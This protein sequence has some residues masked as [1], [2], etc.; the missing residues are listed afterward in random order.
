MIFKYSFFI[1]FLA[2]VNAFAEEVIELS[3]PPKIWMDGEVDQKL[4][5]DI[6][7]NILPLHDKEVHRPL[8]EKQN[9]TGKIRVT[10][11][12]LD[13]FEDLTL[14]Q[15]DISGTTALFD[16][17]LYHCLADLSGVA[18]HDAAFIALYDKEPVGGLDTPVTQ[19]DPS[20]SIDVTKTLG[21]RPLKDL[22]FSGWIYKK[23]PS[24][25]RFS[26]TVSSL[27]LIGCESL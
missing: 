17:Y 10:N 11:K 22:R 19:G 6:I 16:V 12:R 20:I 18:G 24:V 14:S 21:D 4:D 15:D 26:D 9:Y 25:S 1:L 8:L 2:S 5:L 13:T 27:F 3:G 7:Q 23:Y